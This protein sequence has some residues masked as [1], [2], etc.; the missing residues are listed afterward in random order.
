MKANFNSIINDVRPVIVDFS[1]EWCGPCKLQSPILKEVATELDDRVKIIK[2]DVD[3]NSGIASRFNIL[4]VPT[5]MIFKNGQ[6]KYR[7]AG[8]HTKP[9]IMK[10]LLSF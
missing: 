8:V 3:Q 10:I 1:A 7:Q 5:L 4:S 9:Q 2:I 6:V